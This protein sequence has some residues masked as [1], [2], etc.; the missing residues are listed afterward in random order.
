MKLIG[1]VI[2]TNVK[3]PQRIIEVVLR[4]SDETDVVLETKTVHVPFRGSKEATE[5]ILS[6]GIKDAIR[7]VAKKHEESGLADI[8]NIDRTGD[9]IN[10][11][12]VLDERPAPPKPIIPEG[13]HHD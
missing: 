11:D 9:E 3:I 13:N 10:V 8:S 2:E 6:E 12:T 1:R 5:K 7:E 4:V